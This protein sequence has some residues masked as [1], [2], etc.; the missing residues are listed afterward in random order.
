M[1]NRYANLLLVWPDSPQVP[2]RS[3]RKTW[4]YPK[5]WEG[6]KHEKHSDKLD[7]LRLD[8]L[9]RLF[10]QHIYPL[11]YWNMWTEMDKQY[12]E[13]PQYNKTVV[14]VGYSIHSNQKEY[15]DAHIEEVW[16]NDRCCNVQIVSNKDG[17]LSMINLTSLDTKMTITR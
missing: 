7:S 6:W 14:R 16:L 11:Y 12:S 15:G 5:W 17:T 2:A 4:K 9:M 3:T 8:R 1:T 10:L 13:Q